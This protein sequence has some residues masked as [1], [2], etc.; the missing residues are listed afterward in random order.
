MIL[1]TTALAALYPFLI[2]LAEKGVET[3]VET[4]VEQF[5]LGSVNW[6]K[7]LFFKENKPKKALKELMDEPKSIEKQ[8]AIK[9]LVENSIEDNPENEIYL[10]ELL[11]KLP[12]I[13][14]HISNSKNVITGNIN[15]GGGNF[16]NG[17]GNQI[18]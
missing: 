15:T 1:S 16:I 2:N 3:V 5:T 11:E 4:G 18:S 7:S 6:L 10:K 12:K 14:N 9:T 8:N 17:D 13:E